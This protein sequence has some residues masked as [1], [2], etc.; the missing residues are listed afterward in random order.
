MPDLRFDGVAVASAEFGIDVMQAVGDCGVLG[1][2][3]I[4]LGQLVSAGLHLLFHVAQVVEHRHA[5]GEDGAAGER[6][7]RPAADSPALMPL[8]KLS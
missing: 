7:D 3:R 4:Q 1:A 5:F 8:A 2:G 6:Q